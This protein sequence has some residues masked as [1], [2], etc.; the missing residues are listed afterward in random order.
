MFVFFQADYV[1]VYAEN[2]SKINKMIE[3]FPLEK[4]L[5][6]WVDWFLDTSIVIINEVSIN[7]F[8]SITSES[9]HQQWSEVLINVLVCDD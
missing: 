2:D 6:I 5:S 4:H 1:C 9:F 8:Y 3:F 7:I